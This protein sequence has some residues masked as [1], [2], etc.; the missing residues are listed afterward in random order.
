MPNRRWAAPETVGYALDSQG[1]EQHYRPS[2]QHHEQPL[3]RFLGAPCGGVKIAL[4]N[5]SHTRT[6]V[7]RCGIED[8]V[9]LS[10]I[11]VQVV[12]ITLIENRNR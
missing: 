8:Y 1:S 7:S 9:T 5:L 6:G 4:I 12:I 10:K 2:L 11:L 3:G